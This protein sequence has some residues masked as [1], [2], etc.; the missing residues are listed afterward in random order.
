M[1]ITLIIAQNV[2]GS[3]EILKLVQRVLGPSRVIQAE[4]FNGDFG[5]SQSAALVFKTVP[6]N[7]NFT[8]FY[9]EQLRTRKIALICISEDQ[10]VAEEFIRTEKSHLG[11]SLQFSMILKPDISENGL[12]SADITEKFTELKR[13]LKDVH[14]MP[15]DELFAEIEKVYTAHD[16]CALCTGSAGRLRATPIEYIYDSGRLYFISEGGE[17]F[18]N[19]AANPRASV[20]IYNAYSG[21]HELE[22]LQAEGTVHLVENFSEEYLK[23]MKRKGLAEAQLKKLPSVLNMFYVQPEHIEILKSE[24]KKRGYSVKQTWTNWTEKN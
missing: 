2:D 4:N 24:F 17:K 1:D 22:G 11:A 9:E 5:G 20:A 19:L 14:D 8:Q 12:L 16:T 6:G 3:E 21:F 15:E 7:L 13:K 23:V 18:A 10:S